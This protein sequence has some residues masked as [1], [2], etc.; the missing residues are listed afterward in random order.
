MVSFS[1]IFGLL[2]LMASIV[3]PFYG[4]MRK[5]WKGL[6]LGCLIQPI[7]CI[8]VFGV[9]FG[10]I[11]AYEVLALR[12]Q[13]ESA[14]VAVKTIEQGTNGTDTLKWYLKDDEECF[15]RSEDGRKRYDVIRLDSL[16]AGVSVE[17]RIVV[18]FDLKNQ[19]ATATDYDQPAEILQVDWEKVQTYFEK[20][21]KSAL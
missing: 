20:Q 2:V 17:D 6:A 12:Q 8:V 5:R 4:Y 7:A 18:R 19:K 11:I 15:V 14:M 3:I 1:L 9:V 16:A 10:G 13:C 21:R